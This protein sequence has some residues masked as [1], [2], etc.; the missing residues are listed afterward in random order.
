MNQYKLIPGILV[1]EVDNEAVIVSPE[2]GM[3]TSVNEIG[4]LILSSLKENKEADEEQLTKLIVENYDVLEITAKKDV[5]SFLEEMS[6]NN[7]IKKI[8]FKG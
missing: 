3:I 8:D 6:K 5:K 4:A 2:E 1:Q 7:I